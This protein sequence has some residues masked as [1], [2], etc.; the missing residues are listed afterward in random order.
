MK[1]A[2]SKLEKYLQSNE[3]EIPKM[4]EFLRNLQSLRSGLM[5]HTFSK[6]DKKCKKAL[7]YFKLND[8]NYIEVANDIF[9]KSI[10]TLN[11]LEKQ[12]KLDE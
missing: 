11:T 12:F 10:F 1:K 3:I 7:E 6:S 4:F 2:K 9:I 8:S 5:A